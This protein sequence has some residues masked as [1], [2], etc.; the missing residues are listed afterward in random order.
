MDKNSLLPWGKVWPLDF[1]GD[2]KKMD[3]GCTLAPMIW[4]QWTMAVRF[5]GNSSWRHPM[6]MHFPLA[7]LCEEEFF[8]KVYAMPYKTY[9]LRMIDEWFLLLVPVRFA[10]SP[11]PPGIFPRDVLVCLIRVVTHWCG[12]AYGQQPFTNHLRGP[13]S[14]VAVGSQMF[15]R[16]KTYENAPYTTAYIGMKPPT[17]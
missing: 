3:E 1:L 17:Q 6:F 9:F 13:S 15:I 7:W 11:E 12:D 5:E 8:L 4:V 14:N 10:I 16:I 2:A